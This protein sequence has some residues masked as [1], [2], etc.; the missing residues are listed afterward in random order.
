MGG[1]DAL[2]N[3]AG[4]VWRREKEKKKENVDGARRRGV[5]IPMVCSNVFAGRWADLFRVF[6][7]GPCRGTKEGK[8]EKKK[9]RSRNRGGGK[10]AKAAPRTLKINPAQ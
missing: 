10:M 8:K 3:R 7:P 1:L 4:I 9:E 5:A 2:L 6:E